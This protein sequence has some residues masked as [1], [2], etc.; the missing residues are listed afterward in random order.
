MAPAGNAGEISKQIEQPLPCLSAQERIPDINDANHPDK[1]NQSH[2]KS[3][4]VLL[5]AGTIC[6]PLEEMY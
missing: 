2:V 3:S 4:P 1:G 5:N 6:F